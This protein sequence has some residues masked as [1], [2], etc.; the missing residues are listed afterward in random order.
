[1][2]R[3]T[4]NNLRRLCE[5]MARETGKTGDRFSIEQSSGGFMFQVN[6]SNILRVGYLPARDVYELM[7]AYLAGW[8]DCQDRAKQV[9]A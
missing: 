4:V 3:I 9:A 8:R 2:N 1:M 5:T 7:H 6:D